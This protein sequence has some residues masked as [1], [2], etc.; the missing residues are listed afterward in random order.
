MKKTICLALFALLGL[1]LAAQTPEDCH[2]YVKD[3]SVFWRQV[4]ESP[5][6]STTLLDHLFGSGN[7]ADVTEVS[8]GVSFAIAPRK[9]DT[10]AGGFK[11]GSVAIYVANYTMTAHALLEMKEGRYRVTVDK[12]VFQAGPD[13][14]LETYA[15]NKRME[16]KP[17]FLSMNAAQALDYELTRLFTVRAPE[18]EED[19]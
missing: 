17:I 16:F 7:F 15:L 19:W 3:G 8:N 2:F 5:A 10:R 4:F 9:I 18:K 11:A 12:I 13:T 1:L 14:T 6:D